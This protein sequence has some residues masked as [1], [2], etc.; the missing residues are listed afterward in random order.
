MDTNRPAHNEPTGDLDMTYRDALDALAAA[1]PTLPAKQQGFA[2]SLLSQAVARAD[3]GNAALSQNQ[4]HWV[5]KLGAPQTQTATANVG[6]FGAVIAMFATAAQTK[7]F[8]KITL[9]LADGRAVVLKVA[10]AQSAQP[11]TVTVTDGRPFG[12]NVFYG[13][14]APSG[15]WQVSRTID[16]ETATSVTAL[17]TRFAA[18]PL[19]VAAAHGHETHRCCFCNITLTDP[20]SKTAGYGP[21]CAGKFGLAWG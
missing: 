20:R 21:I 14:V 2:Q 11:G 19:A 7:K 17:L 3:C 8:P 4:W 12:S 1:I 18:E 6:D 5:R 13:R 9:A 16:T 10:G 15:D